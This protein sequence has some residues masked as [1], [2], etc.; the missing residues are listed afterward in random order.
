[1]STAAETDVVDLEFEMGPREVSFDLSEELYPLDAVYGASYVYVDRCYVWLTRP[2]ARTVRVRLR[3]REDTSA[4]AL[5]ALA[6]E[7]GN[8]LLNQVLR[9]R[10]SRST[11]SIREYY[12]ARAFYGSEA[13]STI[14]ALL[15][16]LDEEEMAQAPLE[17]AVPWEGSES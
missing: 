10:I 6:G 4:E 3:T 9:D 13:R 8:E 5:H 15:A 12:M 11:S 1:M 16:E 17:I 14:D 7:F 2:A